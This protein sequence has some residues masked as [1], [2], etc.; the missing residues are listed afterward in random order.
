MVP[1]YRSTN[2]CTS[3]HIRHRTVQCEVRITASVSE[4]G[5]ISR[6]AHSFG[7]GKLYICLSNKCFK[8]HPVYSLCIDVRPSQDHRI[9]RMQMVRINLAL[10]SDIPHGLIWVSTGRCRL[11]SVHVPTDSVTVEFK[12]NFLNV[13]SGYHVDTPSFGKSGAKV[14][15]V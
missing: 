5:S 2:V 1:K 9:L 12:R 13:V 6:V 14:T 15:A 7:S 4:S 11:R 8:V 10:A 3:H